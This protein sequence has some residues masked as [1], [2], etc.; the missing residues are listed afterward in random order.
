MKF[1]LKALRFRQ[2]ALS[3][4]M[5]TPRT[6]RAAYPAGLG[7]ELT[8]ATELVAGELQPLSGNWHSS[9]TRCS[10]IS[11]DRELL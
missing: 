3:T 5:V 2:P 11:R 8:A 10:K 1:R 9:E 6:I 4:A 7:M